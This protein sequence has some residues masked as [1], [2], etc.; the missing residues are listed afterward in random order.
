MPHVDAEGAATC[1]A[2]AGELVETAFAKI[3]LALH[4][5]HKRADGYHALES[6]FVFTELG[7]RL[8][9]R[10]R[11]DGAISLDIDGPFGSELDAGLG[12]LVMKAALALQS[13]LGEGHGADLRLSKM[14]P[15]ASG[16]GGGSADAA[17]TLRLL[18]R[19]WHAPLS[20]ET[21]ERI[22][23]SLGSDVPACVSS[24]SRMVRG[25]GEVLEQRAIAG[26]SG[27]PILL[28]NP[29]VA[30]S[31][32]RV[33]GGW[34]GGDR[35]PLAASELEQVI[36]AGR[37]DLEAPAMAAAPVIADVLAALRACE[38]V[39][40]ARMSGSGATCFALF[41]TDRHSAQAAERLRA[42]HGGWWIAETRIRTE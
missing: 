26:L 25:R 40:L 24:V 3:N 14:L 22:A 4:V 23:L 8:S 32:A 9:G 12:N 10:T 1:S 15:V 39:R 6:L 2:D 20:D 34:D 29:G 33:F 37:N 42:G 16:I 19:L 27:T 35:G 18:A 13:H 5:R 36:T 28:V 30:L 17:A 11:P 31:T 7:D 38:G 41:E 21:L